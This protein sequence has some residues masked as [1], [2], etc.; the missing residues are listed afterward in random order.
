MERKRLAG[1][2]QAFQDEYIL[3][4]VSKNVEKANKVQNEFKTL[5]PAVF[6]FDALLAKQL[7]QKLRELLKIYSNV[8]RIFIDQELNPTN[9]KLKPN[10]V[11]EPKISQV[12]WELDFLFE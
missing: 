2:A 9:D 5:L 3:T 7:S 10:Y 11:P 6:Q 4:K 12:D 1:K 8:S